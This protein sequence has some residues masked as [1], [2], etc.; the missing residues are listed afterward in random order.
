MGN[1]PF[2]QIVKHGISL[3]IGL[4]FFLYQLVCGIVILAE[5]ILINL[6]VMFDTGGTGR[7]KEDPQKEKRKGHA[8]Y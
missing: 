3:G 6:G 8:F 4:L 5:K 1:H 2:I 7:K